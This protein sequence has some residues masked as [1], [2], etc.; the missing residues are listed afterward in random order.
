MPF[1]PA[2]T[3]IVLPLLRS[4]YFSATGL[5]VGCMAPDFEY[6]FKMSVAGSHGHSWGGLFYFDLPVTIALSFLF[7]QL[8]K[9][10]LILNLPD[11]LQRRFMETLL[12]NF[13]NGIRHRPLIFVISALLGSSTHIVWDGFTHNS[14]FF[15]QNLSF[16]EGAYFPFQGVM[17]PLWYALQHISTIIGL[18]FLLVYIG[19]KHKSGFSPNTPSI[20]YWLI[21]VL[22]GLS[23]LGL[24]FL[25]YPHDY[26]LGNLVVSSI[27]SICV[28]LI[29]CG[30]IRFQAGTQSSSSQRNSD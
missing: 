23:F 16:Y 25:V 7:H 20:S 19:V 1:T 3:A 26:N 28:A 5:V 15:V 12:F 17:Y 11:F 10:N 2:H 22:L 29:I 6:F 8:V 4:R 13:K 21:F 14:G 24:R 18:F 27:S 9:P 30:L